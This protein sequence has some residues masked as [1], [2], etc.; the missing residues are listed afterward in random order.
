[1]KVLLDTNALIWATD[2]GAQLTAIARQCLANPAA[3]KVVSV[4][5]FWEMA[6]KV[7]LRKLLLGMTPN[8]LMETL[9]TKSE[10]E[11]LGIMPHHLQCLLTLPHHHRDPFDR[12]MIAQA[13]AEGWHV[14]SSD[15][16]WDGYGVTRIW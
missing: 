10:I 15:D 4:A 11:P 5:A 9:V 3:V 1:M 16:K 6:I 14:V 2:D 8:L 13:L 7:S 12:L